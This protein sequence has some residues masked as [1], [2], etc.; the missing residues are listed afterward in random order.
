VYL[1]PR[2]R[3]NMGTGFNFS[4]TYEAR[5]TD[6]WDSGTFFREQMRRKN[7]YVSAGVHWAVW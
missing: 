4:D 6:P 3:L 5:Y 7:G 2:L 1:S